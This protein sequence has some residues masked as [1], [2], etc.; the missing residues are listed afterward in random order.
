[1]SPNIYVTFDEPRPCVPIGRC[2]PSA[3]QGLL[4]VDVDERWRYYEQ[5][6]GTTRTVP[7]LDGGS[8]GHAATDA[9]D[10]TEAET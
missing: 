9:A 3:A 6:A 2:D 8:V 1:M 7:Y 5:L 4:R 10:E